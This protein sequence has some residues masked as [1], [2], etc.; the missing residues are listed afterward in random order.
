MAVPTIAGPPLGRTLNT[1]LATTRRPVARDAVRPY[2]LFTDVARA[3]QMTV[4]TDHPAVEALDWGLFPPTTVL[5]WHAEAENPPVDPHVVHVADLGRLPL[6]DGSSDLVVVAITTTHLSS[7]AEAR[8]ILAPSGTLVVIARP[9]RADAWRRSF[10]RRLQYLAQMLKAHSTIRRTLGRNRT[11]FSEVWAQPAVANPRRL[12]PDPATEGRSSWWRPAVLRRLP[13]RV[14]IGRTRSTDSVLAQV[15]RAARDVCRGDASVRRDQILVSPTGT[16][17][18]RFCTSS[19]ALFAKIALSPSAA[20]RTERHFATLLTLDT[21][22]FGRS[23]KPLRAHPSRP[24][25]FW[26]EAALDGTNGSENLS[27]VSPREASSR[28]AAVCDVLHDLHTATGRLVTLDDRELDARLGPL[29]W[30]LRLCLHDASLRRKADR[31]EVKMR[32][33]LAGARVHAAMCHGDA[34]LGNVIFSP[35]GGVAGLID[36]DMSRHDDFSM[37]DILQVITTTE[38]DRRKM[39]LGDV[40]SAPLSAEHRALVKT[41]RSRSGADAVEESLLLRLLWLDRI[42]LQVQEADVLPDIWIRRNVEQ[43]LDADAD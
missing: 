15:E 1:P 3:R 34:K 23:P 13:H 24:L 28:L 8:R 16:V 7:L 20:R 21:L 14:F 26:F 6:A 9:P 2:L 43:V 29:F 37:L 30:A 11:G 17:A 10:P 4:V 32:S 18:V 25:P 22:G 5:S 38:R 42:R 41:Y 36:W 35:D 27:A 12:D 31:L 40:V 39:T 19:G 33:G